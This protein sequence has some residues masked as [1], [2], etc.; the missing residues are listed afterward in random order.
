MHRHLP[1]ANSAQLSSLEATEAVLLYVSRSLAKTAH[2]ATR[3]SGVVGAARCCWLMQAKRCSHV[4]ELVVVVVV[5]LRSKQAVDENY[6]A[7]V[8]SWASARALG[9]LVS[10]ESAS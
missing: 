7:R 10:V 8:E 9:G 4:A 3:S 1:H 6:C 5:L 2:E